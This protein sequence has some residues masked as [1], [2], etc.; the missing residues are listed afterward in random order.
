[1]HQG[2]WVLISER[3]HIKYVTKVGSN[4]GHAEQS[5]LTLCSLF[6]LLL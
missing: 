1:M 3:W 4:F 2:Y 6:Q 5:A